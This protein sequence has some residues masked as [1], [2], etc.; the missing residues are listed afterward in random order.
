[1]KF[2]AKITILL[3]AGLGACQNANA[4]TESIKPELENYENQFF[5]LDFENDQPSFSDFKKHF[6]TTFPHNDPTLGDVVYDNSKWSQDDMIS[7]EAE[8]GLFASVKF[9][10][11]DAGFDSFRFTTK[12]FF[13]LNETT[14]KILFVFKGSLPSQNGMW[15]AWWLNGSKE[16]TWI[17]QDSMPALTD[18]ALNRYSGKGNYY[19]TPSSVNS[20]DW[21]SAGEIDII[22]NINGDKEVHNTLH[23]C[24]QMCDSQWNDDDAIINCA[25]AKTNDVNPGCSGRT[26]EVEELAGTFACLWEKGAIRFYYWPPEAPVKDAGGPLSAQPD[27][28]SWVDNHL[29]NTVK[30]LETDSQCDDALHQAW[31]CAN[32]AE[33]NTCAFQNMKMIF[34]V[35]LCG[36]WAGNMFDDTADAFNNCQAYIRGEG[37]NNID[38]QSMKIE[39]VSVTQL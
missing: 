6:F 7:V 24:A 28:D 18:E 30:L 37:K 15:P 17:Y 1:M 5:T 20:T 8:N 31:Q 21:P 33:N 29:K 38:N 13:N 4:P 35:T 19:D 22:E 27:V 10:D 3:L 32:C 25:N 26:Y 36:V 14:Q 11:E 39:Y 2:F 34:N 23:T 12:A 16:D 9:K